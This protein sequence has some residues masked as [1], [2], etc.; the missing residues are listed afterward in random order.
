MG[1]KVLTGAATME[2]KRL[3]GL[4]DSLDRPLYTQLQIADMLGVS[5]TTVFRAIHKSGAYKGVRDLPT[6]NEAKKSLERFLAM[7][8]GLVIQ[9]EEPL[10]EE[11]SAVLARLQTE[12][13]K[14]KELQQIG[15]TC[16]DELAAGEP[17]FM[18][19]CGV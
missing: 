2:I 15:D 7:N 14:T 16:V 8:P 9:Q 11:G 4:K 5:E 1:R 19:G 12:I 3:Y 18:K 13:D 6:D 17:D 10:E